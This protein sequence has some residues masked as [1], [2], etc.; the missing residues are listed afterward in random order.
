M[1]R[2]GCGLRGLGGALE[3]RSAKSTG[4]R[5][6]EGPA[7]GWSA[8]VFEVDEARVFYARLGGRLAPAERARHR[9]T[10]SP[11]PPP[12]PRWERTR[13]AGARGQARSLGER[14]EP[15][16]PHA[17]PWQGPMPARASSLASPRRGGQ[18]EAAERDVLRSG[19]RSCRGGQ[20]DRS[21]VPQGERAGQP[22]GEAGPRAR[23]APRESTARRARRRRGRRSSR[24]AR[25][26]STPAIPA[27]LARREDAVAACPAATRPPPRGRSSSRS[28][29]GAAA[30]GSE[31]DR[32]RRPGHLA[33]PRTARPPAAQDHAKDALVAERLAEPRARP[34]GDAAECRRVAES[35][36]DPAGLTPEARAGSREPGGRA[37]ARRSPRS[38]LR[39]ASSRPP[40]RGGAAPS[41]PRRREGLRSGPRPSAGPVPRPRRRRPAASSRGRGRRGGARARGEHE[42]LEGDANR[43]GRRARRAARSAPARPP[44]WR[45]RAPSCPSG[46]GKEE[47]LAGDRAGPRPADLGPQGR[48]C[49]SRSKVRAPQ[50]SAAWTAAAIPAGPPPTTTTSAE[51]ADLSPG[52]RPAVRRSRR[53]RACHPGGGPALA[54]HRRH[55]LRHPETLH[56]GRVVMRSPEPRAPAGERGGSAALRLRIPR[57]PSSRRS[58]GMTRTSIPSRTRLEAR[59]AVGLPSNVRGTRS[60]CPSRT[61]VPAPR[62]SPRRTARRPAFQSAA[63]RW[64][65]PAP[66]GLRRS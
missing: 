33:P 20:R 24:W 62:R 52:C 49:S 13:A 17:R 21:C 11:P 34:P 41:R 29:G 4:R 42:A 6:P 46:T 55:S 14:R 30:P 3:A 5:N 35:L 32:S 59:A 39:P 58:L 15:S 18:G 23:A 38:A 16:Q 56:S 26:C 22:P 44:P 8:A 7:L 64:S 65:R 40:P 48:A 54:G 10:T 9:P 27:Q 12:A 51:S 31:R 60:R 37:A 1:P 50:S 53:A 36:G 25:A 2:T 43:A 63:R 45:P 57:D 61:A 47:P 19:T 66:A 28:R